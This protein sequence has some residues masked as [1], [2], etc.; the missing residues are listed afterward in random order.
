MELQKT[1][2][3]IDKR[4]QYSET[5]CGLMDLLIFHVFN[6]VRVNSMIHFIARLIS[7]HNPPNHIHQ[8]FLYIICILIEYL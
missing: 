4:K 3:E 6:N 2:F 7:L 8:Y 5:S 1:V